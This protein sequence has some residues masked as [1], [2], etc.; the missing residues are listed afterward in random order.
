MGLL[1]FFH[2]DKYDIRNLPAQNKDKAQSKPAASRMQ[3]AQPVVQRSQIHASSDKPPV[4]D[5]LTYGVKYIHD[6]MNA[7]MREEVTIS[8]YLAEMENTYQDM[9]AVNDMFGNICSFTFYNI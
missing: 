7:L 6:R 1:N 9:D 2:K 8:R 4:E 5:G 3:K